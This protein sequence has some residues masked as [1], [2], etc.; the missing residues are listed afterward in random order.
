M[1]YTPMTTNFMEKQL[2]SISSTMTQKAQMHKFDQKLAA[3]T[4]NKVVVQRKVVQPVISYDQARKNVVDVLTD[5]QGRGF[6]EH[7]P[8]AFLQTQYEPSFNLFA[9]SRINAAM[10]DASI[11]QTSTV[12]P[13]PIA[14]PVE[15]KVAKPVTSYAQAKNH[16]ADALLVHQGR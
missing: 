13:T 4:D 12:A 2:A 8:G 7:A 10:A 11:K 16:I 6:V 15:Q 1:G 5:H 14:A 9:E 3:S